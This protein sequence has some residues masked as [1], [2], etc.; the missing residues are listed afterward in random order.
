MTDDIER[1]V[2]EVLLDKRMQKDNRGNKPLKVSEA[3]RLS[4]LSQDQ[5][6]AIFEAMKD[7]GLVEECG[8]YEG[9]RTFRITGTGVREVRNG[10]PRGA[11]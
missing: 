7:L 5:V 4:E 1:D 2:L 3:A 11:A 6:I 10:E 8:K 9:E